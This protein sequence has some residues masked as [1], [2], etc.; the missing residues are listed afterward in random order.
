MAGSNFHACR[1]HSSFAF[2]AC[3][4]THTRFW[5]MTGDRE[6]TSGGFPRTQETVNGTI[7][8]QGTEF[9]IG[10][11]YPHNRNVCLPGRSV[12]V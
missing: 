3:V 4:R 5:S 2:R 9:A 6:C 11:D 7:W 12:E 10:V 1:T 8:S